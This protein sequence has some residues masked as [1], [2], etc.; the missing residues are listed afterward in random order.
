MNCHSFKIWT[1]TATDSELLSANKEVLFHIEKCETCKLKLLVLQE[2][3]KHMNWQKSCSPSG[4]NSKLFIDMLSNQLVQKPSVGNRPKYLVSRIA[5]AAVIVFGMLTGAIAGGLISTPKKT[6][7][8]LWSSE[9]T[10]LSDNSI[11]N[12]Y[13]FE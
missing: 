6:D 1:E 12:T 3:V 2:S 8:Q 7:N 4:L 5:V 10:L 11:T 13:V 9:F